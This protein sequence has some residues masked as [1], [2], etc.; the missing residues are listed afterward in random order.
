MRPAHL[1]AI[2]DKEL[3]SALTGEHTPVML[4]GPPGIG[5]SD[6]VNQ[7]GLRNNVPVYVSPEQRLKG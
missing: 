6:I 5:K 4:W 2:L 7:A 1:N 3:T